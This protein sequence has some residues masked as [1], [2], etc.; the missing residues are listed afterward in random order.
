VASLELV[1]VPFCDFG[2]GEQRVVAAEEARLYTA[3]DIVGGRVVPSCWVIGVLP[4]A[5][6]WLVDGKPLNV[7]VSGEVT[8]VGLQLT[9]STYSSYRV[10]TNLA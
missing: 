2:V 1:V 7:V 9:S 3:G 10:M 4:V 6:L 5:V 8:S